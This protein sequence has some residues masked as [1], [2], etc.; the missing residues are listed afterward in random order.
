MDVPSQCVRV[1]VRRSVLELLS[2][3]LDL[4]VTL[5]V[6]VNN[7]NVADALSTHGSAASRIT[8]RR[9]VVKWG[10]PLLFG[11]CPAVALTPPALALRERNEALC[12]TGF[13]T[14]IWQYKCT[15]I[16]DIS[17]EGTKVSLSKQEEVATD[18]LLSKLELTSTNAESDSS[19]NTGV[20]DKRDSSQTEGDNPK[21]GKLICCRP[22]SATNY[23]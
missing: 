21:G 23:Y 1:P 5:F 9:Q 3:I 4:I 18:S 15:E 8:T 14:N 19:E 2:M 22:V 10:L 12:A 7:H 20:T 16:G 17:D 13:Y 6:V 11:A